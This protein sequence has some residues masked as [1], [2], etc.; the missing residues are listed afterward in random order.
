MLDNF[1][2]GIFVWV[3]VSEQNISAKF[4]SRCLMLNRNGNQAFQIFLLWQKILLRVAS[5]SNNNGD[6]NT[7]I[8]TVTNKGHQNY[9]IRLNDS[10][11]N[12]NIQELPKIRR[13]S[14]KSCFVELFLYVELLLYI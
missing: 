10:N 11:D 2:K 5:L 1:L 8:I 3:N 9:E 7:T 12:T 14:K 4:I 13:N 6:N